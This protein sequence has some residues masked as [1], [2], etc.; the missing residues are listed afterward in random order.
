ME[1][2]INGESRQF[3]SSLTVADLVMALN[4][5]GK[6]IAVERNGEI[7]ARGRHAETMLA[8]G[9][10]IEIVVAVGGG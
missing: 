6:R 2:L 10:R 4:H 9:D 1:L 3:P 8:E 5:A 7:V